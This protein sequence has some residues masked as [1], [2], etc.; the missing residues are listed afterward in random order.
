MFVALMMYRAGMRKWVRAV[1]VQNE[2][3][4]GGRLNERLRGRVAP[5]KGT[6]VTGKRR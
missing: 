1:I 3:D 6:K 2:R 5:R 4:G